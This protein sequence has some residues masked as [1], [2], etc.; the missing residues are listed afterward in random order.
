MPSE[1]RDRFMKD[2]H[3]MHHMQGV[4]NGIWSDMFIETT[5]MR[6]G[7]SHGEIIGITLR[8][9]TPK[10]WALGL[11]T[12]SKLVE[13][14]ACMSDPDHAARQ[15][16]HKKEQKSRIA[17]DAADRATIRET[18]D[19]SIDPLSTSNEPDKL[20]NI[21]SGRVAPDAVNVNKTRPL[22]P[23]KWKTT[24]ALD[25]MTSTVPLQRRR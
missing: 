24:R 8:P 14:I 6:Y 18:L 11:H 1:V 25:Q 12:R 5:F 17:A 4:W 9:K 20:V 19:R 13:D 7:N 16:T 2:E 15:Y 10:T 3:V 23:N 21:V 22:E